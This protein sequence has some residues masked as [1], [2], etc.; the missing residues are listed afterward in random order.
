M[1]GFYL[2]LKQFAHFYSGLHMA[3]KS[4]KKKLR[5]ILFVSAMLSLTA[6]L[7]WYMGRPRF[8]HYNDFGIDIPVNYSMHG[9]DVSKYQSAIDWADVKQM[10][11]K[12]ISIKFSFIKATEGSDGVDGKFKRNWRGTKE[13]G[14]PRGAYHFFN[15]Y[16][17]GKSQALNFISEV[18][19]QKGDM[20]PVLDIEQTGIASKE[21]LQQRI[22]EWLSI[23]ER[24]YKTKPII[25][26]GADFYEKYL[27]GKFDEYPLWV[28]HYLAKN[29]PRVKRNWNFW[30]H[31][32]TGRVNGI[33]AYVDFNVFNGDSAA[34]QQM[35]IK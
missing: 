33:D 11:V 9:I 8:V 25:Y 4:Q 34:F 31:N 5:L 26:T 30:Q 27:A 10:K 16:K 32:E 35:L 1:S 29:K 23:V 18:R 2:L 20:P 13:A 7:I 28:A 6:G 3:K 24:Q 21:I 15:P 14:I 12:G 17:D 22:A 19:L